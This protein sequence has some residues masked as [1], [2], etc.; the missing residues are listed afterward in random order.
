MMCGILHPTSGSVTIDNKDI[1]KY[2]KQINK[3]I[4]EKMLKE[5]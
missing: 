1:L 4:G 2:R 5:K 3:E